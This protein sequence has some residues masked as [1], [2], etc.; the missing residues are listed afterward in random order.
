MSTNPKPKILITVEGGLIQSIVATQEMDV[1][2]VDFDNFASGDYET[3]QAAE[4][5]GVFDPREDVEL[6]SEQAFQTYLGVAK[7]NAR[8]MIED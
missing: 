7:E 4:A 5:E 6:V 2:V 3:F 8:E 1:Y